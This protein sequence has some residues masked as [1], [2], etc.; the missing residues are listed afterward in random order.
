MLISEE[1]GA[2]SPYRRL[3]SRYTNPISVPIGLS[4]RHLE[5]LLVQKP[6]KP[7]PIVRQRSKLART[8]AEATCPKISDRE[9]LYADLKKVHEHAVDLGIYEEVERIELARFGSE[10]S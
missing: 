4:R 10:P 7:I 2:R 9:Q 6:E 8:V 5:T 1:Y 3:G